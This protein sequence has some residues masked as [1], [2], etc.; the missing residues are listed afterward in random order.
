MLNDFS[1]LSRYNTVMAPGYDDIARAYV[2]SFAM[3]PAVYKSLLAL[4]GGE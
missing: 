2:E 4:A 1:Q 3:R